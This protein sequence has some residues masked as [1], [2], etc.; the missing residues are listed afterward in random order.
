[1]RIMI[2]GP[3]RSGTTSEAERHGHLRA[4]NEAAYQVFRRGHTPI[5]GARVMEVVDPFGN[6]RRFSESLPAG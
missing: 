6:R 1:M 5:I 2:A 3:S 4:L